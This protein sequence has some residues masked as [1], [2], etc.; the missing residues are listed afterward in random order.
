MKKLS[1]LFLVVALS[2]SAF[3]AEK[4]DGKAGA[5]VTESKKVDMANIDAITSASIVPTAIVKEYVPKGFTA[6]S[7]THLFYF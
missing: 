2:I 4:A 1:L 7:Y 6:V 3:S 5:S